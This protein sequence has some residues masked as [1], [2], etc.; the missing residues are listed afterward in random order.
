MNSRA[1]LTL[2]ILFFQANSHAMEEQSDLTLK[3]FIPL[4]SKK[5]IKQRI[6]DTAHQLSSEYPGKPLTLVMVMKGALHI[7]SDLSRSLENA[8]T[9]EFIQASSYGAN[10]TQ[11]GELTVTGLEKLNLK[12]KDVLL[13]D[14][15][16]DTGKTI[17]R[18][19]A[20]LL[21]QNPASLKTVVL[22]LKKKERDTKELPDYSL[23]T[24]ENEFVI[25][26]GLDYKEQF[27]ELPDIW[28]KK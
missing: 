20:E 24:I 3:N 10:G 26:Y 28:V 8:T 21:K 12:G 6:H 22:L 25:G 9:L 4:I 13:I 27:R 1:F 7:T 18:V 5:A 15:I 17:T 2:S 16:F 11:S 19:K 23:F 14:D